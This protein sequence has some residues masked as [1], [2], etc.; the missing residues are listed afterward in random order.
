MKTR[1]DSGTNLWAY[2]RTAQAALLVLGMTCAVPSLYAGG[3]RKAVEK[4]KPEY[5]QL[6]R[7]LHLH[8]TV[9]IEAV[10]APSG[11]V[12]ETN[13][14]G[15][16]PVLADAAVRALKEWKFEPGSTETTQVFEF[17]FNE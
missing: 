6:A 10:I 15:G 8:G 2:S 3:N 17:Q 16:H 11:Q 1:T 13:I 14:L 5:P 9:K 7:Q 4:P 12:K